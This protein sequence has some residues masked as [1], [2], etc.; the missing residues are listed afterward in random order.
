MPLGRNNEY[1][2]QIRLGIGNNELGGPGTHP[3]IGGTV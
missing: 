1:R 2:R 3:G